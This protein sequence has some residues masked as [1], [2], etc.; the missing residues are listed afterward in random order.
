[1]R[2]QF[3]FGDF[4][5]WMKST[6]SEQDMDGANYLENKVIS[7]VGVKKLVSV[8]ET[9]EDDVVELAEEFKKNG[10]TVTLVE[11]NYLTVSTDQGEFLIRKQYVELD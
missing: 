7:K 9:D 1:M 8:M 5:K 3:D 11:G 6:P 2:Q 4:K 10:G